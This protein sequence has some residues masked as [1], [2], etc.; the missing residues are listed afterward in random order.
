MSRKTAI[1]GKTPRTRKQPRSRE[2]VLDECVTR[3][4]RVVA[5]LVELLARSEERSIAAG[6]SKARDIADGLAAIARKRAG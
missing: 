6:Q 5:G 3:L 1:K 4:L 2:E